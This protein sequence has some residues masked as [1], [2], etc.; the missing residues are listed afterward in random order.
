[1]T[2][3]ATISAVLESIADPLGQGGLVSSRRAAAPK[4]S[5][6]RVSLILDVTGL[7]VTVRETLP[8]AIRYSLLRLDGVSSSK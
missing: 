3:I 8:A 7:A 6:G 2:D 1:M 5:E 4:F